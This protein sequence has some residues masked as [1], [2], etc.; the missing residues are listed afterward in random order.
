MDNP[1]GKK[2]KMVTTAVR[3]MFS[4]NPHLELEGNKKLTLEGSRGVLSYSQTEIKVNLGSY[5]VSVKG[6]GLNLKYISSTSLVIEGLFNNIEFG[7]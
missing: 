1:K 6:R 5:S 3:D 2:I 7:V 4:S